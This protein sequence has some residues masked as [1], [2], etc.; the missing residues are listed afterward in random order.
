MLCRVQYF[1]RGCTVIVDGAQRYVET[2]FPDGCSAGSTP[3]DDEHTL[4][5]AEEMG[6]GTDTW[7]MS[8][9]HELAHTWLAHVAG[10]EFSPTMWRIAH[11]DLEDSIGDVEVSEEEARVLEFQRTMPKDRVRPW[12]DGTI[13][14]SDD[15]PW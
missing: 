12:D 11:P 10:L 9:D 7:A 4:E 3:N 1:F 15:L 5:V 8:R 2:R 14:T 13:R 6:Y